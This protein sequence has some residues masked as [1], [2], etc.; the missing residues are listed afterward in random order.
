MKTNL[1]RQV[2]TRHLFMA[3]PAGF[4]WGLPAAGPARDRVAFLLRMPRPN[5][6]LSL[7]PRPSLAGP[8]SRTS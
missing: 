5:A 1:L 7:L 4:A 8:T 3:G 6:P 2:F